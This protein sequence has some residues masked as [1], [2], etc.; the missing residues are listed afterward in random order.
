MSVDPRLEIESH[1]DRRAYEGARGGD[2]GRDLKTV[3]PLQGD[4][5]QHAG[6]ARQGYE[7]DLDVPAHS[8]QTASGVRMTLIR[9]RNRRKAQTNVVDHAQLKHG[10][11]FGVL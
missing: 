10:R 5:R 6:H 2:A 7:G 3:I 8:I 9:G 11:S 1:V 4:E